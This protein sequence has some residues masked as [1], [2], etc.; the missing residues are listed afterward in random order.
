MQIYSKKNVHKN[1]V[2]NDQKKLVSKRHCGNLNYFV[3]ITS[4]A[5]VFLISLILT[6]SN[7]LNFNF[8]FTLFC[9]F[10][11]L[12]TIQL[13]FQL[14]SLLLSHTSFSKAQR[15]YKIHKLLMSREFNFGIEAL[16]TVFMAPESEFSADVERKF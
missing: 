3:S 4:T 16:L 11:S 2:E 14:N 5:T 15:K 7:C 9:I 10:F 13:T 1:Q 8:S 12:P 6:T